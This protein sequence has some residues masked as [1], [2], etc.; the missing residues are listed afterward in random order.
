[1]EASRESSR[2]RIDGGRKLANALSQRGLSKEPA[3]V[4]GIWRFPGQP[5]FSRSLEPW[6]KVAQLALDWFGKYFLSPGWRVFF[7]APGPKEFMFD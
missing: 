3:I 4:L 7:S 2:D 1:M 6:K 5:I